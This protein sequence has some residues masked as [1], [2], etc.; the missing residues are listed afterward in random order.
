IGHWAL[1]GVFVAKTG[2]VFSV[3]ADAATL[4]ASGA[5]NRPDLVGA[6]TYLRGVGPGTKWFDTSAFARPQTL[7]LG[8]AGRNILEGPGLTNYDFGVFR[9]IPIRERRRLQIRG[10]FFNLSNTP[11]FN[12]P[13]AALETTT[14]G[15]VS[16]AF[17][18]R[19]VQLG[20]KLEF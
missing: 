10:E 9:T 7:R 20:A 14:F 1:N 2:N 12:N 13:G 11:H 6:I 3:S 18:D 15:T 16:T 4:N 17:G 19:R 8:N 5:A